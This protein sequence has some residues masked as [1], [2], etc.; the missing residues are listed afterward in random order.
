VNGV[1]YSVALRAVNS[2]GAG[3]A[4]S[5]QHGIPMTTP[6][7]P[8]IIVTPQDS[9]LSVSYTVGNSGGS[10]VTGVQYSVGG[11]WVSVGSLQ[12]TFS[13]GS[14]INGASYPVQVRLVNAVGAGAASAITPASPRSVPTAPLAVT[15]VPDGGQATIGWLA[16]A[17]DGGSPVTGYTA[18]AWSSSSNGSAIGSCTTTDLSCVVTG[19]TNGI[20]YFVSVTA[21]NIAGDG[22][23]SAPRAAVVPLAKPDAPTIDG[24]AAA[25]TYLTVYFSAGDPGSTPITGFEYSFNGIDWLPTASTDSPLI[26]SGLSNGTTY[27]VQLRADNA[28]G[29]GA[30]SDPTDG[31]PYGV[32]DVPDASQI[33]ATAGNYWADVNWVAPNDNGSEIYNY[34]VTAWSSPVQGSQWGSC[35]TSG[36]TSCTLYLW[37]GNS[38]YITVEA[39][40]AAG[41]TARSAPRLEVTPGAPGQVADL[42]GVA[43]NHKVDLSWTPGDDG[44]GPTDGYTVWYAPV[45]VSNFTQFGDVWSGND[46]MVTGL[47]N[48]TPYVFKVYAENWVGLGQPATSPPYTPVAIGEVPTFGSPTPTADGFTATILRYDPSTLYSVTSDHGTAALSGDSITVNGLDAG[49]QATVTV[50]AQAAGVPDEQ[51]TVTGSALLAGTVPEFGTPVRTADGYTVE[52][53]NSASGVLYTPTATDGEVTLSGTT[54]TVV[55][56]APGDSSTI[57]LSATQDGHTDSSADVTGSAL[58]TGVAAALGTPVR[59]ADGYFVPL[60]NLRDLSGFEYS[61]TAGTASF[62]FAGFTISG[63]TPGQSSTFTVRAFRRGSTDAMSTA[64]DAALD[65]GADMRTGAMYQFADG[66]SF[67]LLGYDPSFSYSISFTAGTMTFVDG[68]V[69]ISGLAIGEES[70][71]WIYATQPGHTD[72]QVGVGGNPMPLPGTAPVLTTP[73]STATGFTTTISNYSDVSDYTV[74]V[75]A[76][77]VSLDGTL[78]TVTGLAAGHS[79]TVT[80]SADQLGYSTASSTALGSAIA[81]VAPVITPAVSV[82]ADTPPASDNVAPDTQLFSADSP[83]AVASAVEPHAKATPLPNQS[84][85][86]PFTI[87][88]LVMLIAIALLIAWLRRRRRPVAD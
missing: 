49:Q 64:E 67:P 69:T 55:D 15:A 41:T 16:P 13:I 77:Q 5:T 21:T 22:A 25:N 78:V 2:A 80:V 57:T 75:D 37:E 6:S 7:A 53:L 44:D 45:G 12:T 31:T 20:A 76:G 79:A 30:S 32:P 60:L 33:T 82:T 17:S 29:A 27:S 58:E 59:T 11:G 51:G 87:G 62:S 42:T 84:V 70:D 18:T 19:L 4:S 10:S 83:P 40:N 50:T 88:A 43:S 35:S 65:A 86:V 34:T 47:T 46:A 14:L 26:I 66:F 48:G 36:E 71:V 56:L 85:W 9:G 81:A 52:L 24:I 38:F 61:V 63:L 1:S 72:A 73:V 54:L 74:T 8:T 23:A 28:S 3:T 68:T 39:T